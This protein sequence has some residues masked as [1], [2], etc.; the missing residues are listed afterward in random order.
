MYRN[1]RGAGE[2]I[3]II[4]AIVIGVLA[5]VLIAVGFTTGWSNLWEK[6]NL[7]S[8]G[9]GSLSSAAEACTI[10]CGKGEAGKTAWC[11]DTMDVKGLTETQ[12]KLIN[13]G[14]SYDKK[15][16]LASVDLAKGTVLDG[17]IVVAALS[18]SKKTVDVSGITCSKLKEKTLIQVDCDL[19]C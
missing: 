5:L 19:S 10:T 9:K 4:I 18:N 8:G 6:F 7:F 17:T 14:V 15:F 13:T 2:D 16:L 1:K 11:G 12:V 3:W